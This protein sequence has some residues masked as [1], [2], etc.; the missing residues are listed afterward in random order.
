MDQGRLR[1]AFASTPMTWRGG[2]AQLGLLAS[3]LRQRGHQV[4][5]LAPDGS[6]LAWSERVPGRQIVAVPLPE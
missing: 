3:G 2:E 6:Q 4:T 5:V 1:F